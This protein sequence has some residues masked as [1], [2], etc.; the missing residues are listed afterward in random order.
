MRP[1]TEGTWEDAV[2][3]K[4]AAEDDANTKTLTCA[5]CY[6]DDHVFCGDAPCLPGDNGGQQMVFLRPDVY[7]LMR[8]RGEL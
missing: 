5:E 7:V 1:A 4:V 2:L 8:L 6:F 3:V